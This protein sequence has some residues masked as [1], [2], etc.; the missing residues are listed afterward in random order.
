[1][2][3]LLV[4]T[5]HRGARAD[6]GGL[7]LHTALSRVMYC[8]LGL[9]WAPRAP[10]LGT[11][12]VPHTCTPAQEVA[13]LCIIATPGK[14]SRLDSWL[15]HTISCSRLLKSRLATSDSA[16]PLAPSLQDAQFTP[17]PPPPPPHL[18]PALS[19][20]LV[21]P[22]RTRP[23]INRAPSALLATAFY[24]HSPP[25][26]VARASLSP[27]LPT[28]LSVLRHGQLGRRGC[29]ERRA[30]RGAGTHDGRGEG[31]RCPCGRRCHGCGSG[32]AAR[33]RFAG[34]AVFGRRHSQ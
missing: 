12:L 11:L 16:T 26:L 2:D 13:P 8:L 10:R 31:R 5:W 7:L 30:R 27:V 9:V 4:D 18:K 28:A 14:P 3:S 15:H 17:P 19:I 29:G 6:V 1:M 20:L 33:N 32:R 22:G 24:L 21:T 34:V 23:R 25:C